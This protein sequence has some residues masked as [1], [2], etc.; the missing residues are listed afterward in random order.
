M[1][2]ES[3]RTHFLSI[4]IDFLVGLRDLVLPIGIGVFFG[5][6][7]FLDQAGYLLLIPPALLIY[8]FFR[9][10][11]LRYEITDEHFHLRSGVFIRKDRYIKIPRIQTVQVTTNVLIRPF[12]LVRL[13]FDTADADKDDVVLTVL[14]KREADRIKRLLGHG[15]DRSAEAT[16]RATDLA[17]YAQ[18]EAQQKPGRVYRLSG[19]DLLIAAMISSQIGVILGAAGALFS[20]VDELIPDDF[21]DSSIRYLEHLTV[22]VIG[23]S[24]VAA[25]LLLW[26]ASI[27]VMCIRWGGFTLTVTEE[28]WRIQKG[29][30]QTTNETYKLDRVQALRIEEH[31]LQQ[32][33]GFCT[34]YAE[35]TGSVGGGEGGSILV[36]PI[37]R[38]ASAASFFQMVIPRFSGEPLSI[39]P[40]PQRGRLYSAIK[41]VFLPIVIC[42]VLSWFFAWG[43]WTWLAVPV[44]FVWSLLA[45]RSTGFYLKGNRVA[46]SN[47]RIFSKTTAITLKKHIQTFSRSESRI[48]RR[49]GLSSCSI[50]VRGSSAIH[51]GISEMEPKDAERL[52]QWFRYRKNDSSGTEDKISG[53]RA[54]RYDDTD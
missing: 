21:Y 32:L 11:R 6:R 41:S 2:Y 12:G 47:R 13:K 49:L 14:K 16:E 36:F 26:L 8:D 44:I 48:Q 52:F 43:V 40:I 31:W 24:I 3:R 50:A 19:K 5:F 46:F 42:S 28:E 17:S 29:L 53:D 35:A 27:A 20:Q 10:L 33:F 30:I 22:I 25:V 38:K 9:W 39:H 51:Y 34:V 54:P 45:E 15:D 7:H 23:L 37:V 1:K 18:M 4:F